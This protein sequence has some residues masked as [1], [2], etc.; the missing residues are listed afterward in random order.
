MS[1]Y[2]KGN[3]TLKPFTM[4][5]RAGNR[6]HTEVNGFS[7]TGTRAQILRGALAALNGSSLAKPASI[8]PAKKAKSQQNRSSK[9]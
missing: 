7:L 8:G 6:Y 3:N 2:D 4:S 1:K 5:P 9:K